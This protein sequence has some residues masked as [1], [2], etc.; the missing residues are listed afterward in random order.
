MESM[1]LKTSR[2]TEVDRVMSDCYVLRYSCESGW[3]HVDL[4]NFEVI[5]GG[6]ESVFHGPLGVFRSRLKVKAQ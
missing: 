5:N 3:V 6:G 1:Y 4:H 2:L